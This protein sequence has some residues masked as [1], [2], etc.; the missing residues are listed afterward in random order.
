MRVSKLEPKRSSR[1]FFGIKRPVEKRC[2]V[3]MAR[4]STIGGLAM[5]G[6]KPLGDCEGLSRAARAC[7]PAYARAVHVRYRFTWL[8]ARY[9]FTGL[10]VSGQ[11]KEFHAEA[12][13]RQVAEP[14]RGILP[15]SAS[16]S[17]R[18]E[19]CAIVLPRLADPQSLSLFR[20]WFWI[21][22]ASCCNSLARSTLTT[23]IPEGTRRVVGAKFRMP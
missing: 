7:T 8:H 6:V 2:P 16:Q 1:N 12:R 20:Q 19:T 15:V 10:V 21:R 17:L 23:A 3:Q 14:L 4:T 9:R 11:D 13:R 18:L 22:K 5:V